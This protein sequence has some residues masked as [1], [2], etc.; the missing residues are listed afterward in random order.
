M[1]YNNKQKANWKIVASGVL[2]INPPQ[3]VAIE[4]DGDFHNTQMSGTGTQQVNGTT[5]QLIWEVV[6]VAP[7]AP[8]E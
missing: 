6:L 5:Y 7:A 8:E 3:S 4:L 1:L 2:P